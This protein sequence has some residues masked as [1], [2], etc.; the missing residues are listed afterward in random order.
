M[1]KT[2]NYG[3]ETKSFKTIM[4]NVKGKELLGE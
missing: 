4:E 3:E 2:N 1:G